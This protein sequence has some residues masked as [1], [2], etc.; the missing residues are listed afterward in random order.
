[1]GM[2]LIAVYRDKHGNFTDIIDN[3][4]GNIER[5]DES[6]ILNNFESFISGLLNK[7]FFDEKEKNIRCM[8]VL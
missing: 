4:K 2:S 1:M 7:S 8:T 5:F 6:E 3:Y